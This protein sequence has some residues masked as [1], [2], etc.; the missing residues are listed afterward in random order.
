MKALERID[1]IHLA[2]ERCL[3]IKDL[4]FTYLRKEWSDP[5]SNEDKIK[6]RKELKRFKVVLPRLD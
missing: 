5:L 3:N 4:C 2:D 1:L 6:L